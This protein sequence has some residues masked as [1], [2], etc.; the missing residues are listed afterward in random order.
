MALKDVSHWVLQITHGRTTAFFIA[1]F[2]A[3]NTLA[4]LHNAAGAPL[5]TS[6]YVYFMATLGGLVL[7]HSV[8]EDLVEMKNRA[9]GTPPERSPD[10]DHQA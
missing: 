5:L 9:N 6:T 4:C 8:K 7:G 2:V 1:F 10:A 3:G